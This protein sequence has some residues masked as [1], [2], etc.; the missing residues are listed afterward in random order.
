MAEQ[1]IERTTR[2][3]RRARWPVA[4]ALLGLY[5]GLVVVFRSGWR[6]ALTAIRRFNRAVLNPTMML[7]AGRR[8][9]YASVVRHVGRRS[10]THY[11]TPVL[12]EPGGTRVYIPLPYGRDVDWLRN[13]LA[14]GSCTL[15]MR[16]RRYEM[17]EPEVV[18]AEAAMREIPRRRASQLRFFGVQWF[19]R[20]TPCSP[21]AGG[22]AQECS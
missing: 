6:P 18:T 20:L 22:R 19:V 14:A 3:G 2:R 8:H 4:L 5:A 17:T 16:G 15:D 10:G 7:L 1:G 9:W 11:A 12:A 21:T 13:V